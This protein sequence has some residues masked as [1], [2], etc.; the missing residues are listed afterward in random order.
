MVK[1]G[2]MVLSQAGHLQSQHLEVLQDKE[3]EGAL[4]WQSPVITITLNLLQ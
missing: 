3:G 2:S 4:L 1:M